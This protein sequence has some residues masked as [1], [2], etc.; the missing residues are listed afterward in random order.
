VSRAK[1]RPA[2]PGRGKAHGSP[3]PLRPSPDHR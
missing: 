1:R 2:T 3:P